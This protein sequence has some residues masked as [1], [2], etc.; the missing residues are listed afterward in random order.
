ML[1]L[2]MCEIPAPAHDREP[3]QFVERR[4]RNKLALDSRAQHSG[5]RWQGHR[6]GGDRHRPPPSQSGGFATRTPKLHE[7]RREPRKHQDSRGTRPVTPT[8]HM[9]DERCASQHHRDAIVV[10]RDVGARGQVYSPRRWLGRGDD[11]QMTQMFAEGSDFAR[12]AARISDP[13][14]GC[15]RKQKTRPRGRVLGCRF[16]WS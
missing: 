15:L 8:R 5:V 13:Q 3:E 10:C 1:N 6:F 2:R 12:A 7:I 4:G 16:W 11:P 14:R 9:N